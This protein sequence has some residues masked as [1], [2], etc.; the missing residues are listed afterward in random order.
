MSPRSIRFLAAFA[1]ATVSLSLCSSPSAAENPPG[2]SDGPGVDQGAPDTLELRNGSTLRCRILGLELGTLRVRLAGG[3]EE[4]IAWRQVTSVTTSAGHELVLRDGQRLRG[5]LRPG[6]IP[7]ALEVTS[8]EGRAETVSLALRQVAG[9]D[10]PT[11]GLRLKGSAA[12]GASVS[13]G[14]SNVKAFALLGELSARTDLLRV[15][16][17]GLYNQKEDS[18][19]T[20][21]RN[22]RGRGKCDVFVLPRTYVLGSALFEHD[23]FRDLELRSVYTAGFGHQFVDRGDHPEE[24]LN[25]IRWLNELELSGEAG[26]GWFLED[27]RRGEDQS[28]LAARWSVRLDWD[29]LP[30][31]KIFH[32]HEGFPSLE[33]VKD[34]FVISEQGVRCELGGGFFAALQ[35]NWTWDNTPSRGFDRSDVLYLINLGYLF[36]H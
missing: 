15:S 22:A 29:L 21:A 7:G 32:R 19:S 5:T 13:D 30:R 35:V 2:P 16:L 27:A 26:L 28:Y 36:D 20:T 25:G 12:A 1:V 33:D 4:E 14:N 6:P 34:L 8:G 23:R 24:Y 11:L 10:P 31:V 9:M 3:G 18:G 17:D